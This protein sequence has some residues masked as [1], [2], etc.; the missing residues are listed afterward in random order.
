MKRNLLL[1]L[2]SF[3]VIS[4]IAQGSEKIMEDR[5]KELH[6]VLGL[7]NK[8]D[9]KKFMQENY[10]KALLDKPVKMNKQVSD[11]DGGNESTQSEGLDNLD[12]K[13]QMYAQLHQDFGG[14]KLASL[15][16]TDNKIVMVLK[17][18]TGLTGTFTLTFEKAKPYLIESMGVQAEMEN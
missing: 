11:S 5:A 17:T 2:F 12:A 14:S 1:L 6:R 18:G 16:R 10:T 3:T 13:A 4:A 7:S 8:A 9:Y 15:K